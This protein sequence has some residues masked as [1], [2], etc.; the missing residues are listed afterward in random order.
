MNKLRRVHLKKAI[1]FINQAAEV[2]SEVKEEEQEA[3]DNLPENL[4]GSDRAEAMQDCID[5][6][7]EIQV[8]L[9]DRAAELED[10]VL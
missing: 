2:I 7:C 4:Q 5:I 6:L 8:E 1:E 3:L 10:D 9:E